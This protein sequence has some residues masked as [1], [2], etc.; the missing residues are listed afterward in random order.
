MVLYADA[1]YHILNSTNLLTWMDQKNP[2]PDCFE[3]PDLFPLA[4][5]GD[6]QHTKWVLVRGNGQYSIGE[7]DGA[8]FTAETTRLPG[9][10]GAN[11]YATQSWGDIAGQPGRRVQIAWMRDGKYP[12]MPFNQQLTFPCDL[13]LRSFPEGFRLCRMPVKEI[14]SLY[15]RKHTWK[16]RAIQPGANLLHNVAGEL[17][18][19][20][21]RVELAGAREA[22]LK[23]RGEA[24][25]YSAEK[26]TLTCLGREAKVDVVN[27]QLALRILV[28]RTS[29]EVFA[30]DGK[31]SLSSCFLPGP[32]K[33]GLELF[34]AGGSPKILSMTVNEL[35]PAWP[36]SQ[37]GRIA[38][39]A[40]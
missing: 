4:V 20:Q 5:D 40:W 12:D 36:T 39:P 26:G 9:D 27:G 21:L 30:N 18:D 15:Q 31:V 14:A 13:I 7:F 23:C 2:I 28:D 38:G 8:K 17:F 32:G 29:I 37:A 24:I 11:F 33:T 19:I 25:T 22:G 16:D 35:K 1:H 6:C 3:C 34:A 10:L